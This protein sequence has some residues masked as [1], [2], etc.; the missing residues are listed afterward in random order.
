MIKILGANILHYLEWK[1]ILFEGTRNSFILNDN[2]TQF[3]HHFNCFDITKNIKAKHHCCDN[4]VQNGSCFSNIRKL[5]YLHLLLVLHL[6]NMLL[7]LYF[8]K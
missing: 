6:V 8:S 7:K 5:L 3:V 2:F 1:Y 4:S